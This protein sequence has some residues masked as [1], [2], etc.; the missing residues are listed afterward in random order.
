MKNVL[1]QSAMKLNKKR[2]K[3]QWR[4][5]LVRTLAGVVVFCTTYALILPAITMEAEPSCGMEVHTHE[6]SC[7]T[8]RSEQVFVCKDLQAAH[9]HDDFCYGPEGKLTCPLAE[10]EVHS[11]GEAC[12]QV[13]EELICQPDPELEPEHVHG[14]G[15]YVSQTVLTCE[16][17]PLEAHFHSQGCLAEETR[18]VLICALPEHAHQESCY[19]VKVEADGADGDHLCGMSIHTHAEGCY[20]EDGTLTCSI[21]EHDHE[22][23][24]LVEDLDLNADKEYWLQWVE[25]RDR[26]TFTGNWS[27]DVLTVAKA[28]LGYRE[29]TRN[30]ILVEDALKG[31]TRFGDWYGLP[32]GDWCAMYVSFC[33]DFAQVEGVPLDCAVNPWIDSLKNAE[34]YGEAGIYIPRAG[35]IIFFDYE[36]T[37]EPGIPVI[38]DHVGLVTE[39]LLSEDGQSGTITTIEGN[40]EDQ[41]LSLTYDAKDPRIIG[42]GIL[43]ENPLPQEQW[44]QLRDVTALVE[45]L[46]DA[47]EV[48]TAFDALNL[49]GDK[50]GFEA[51][52]Q[53]LITHIEPILASWESFTEEQKSRAPSLDNVYAL[54]EICGGAAWQELPALAE[55]GAAVTA[56][57]AG[58]PEIFRGELPEELSFVAS[59]Q[60][61]DSIYN[62]DSIRYPFTVTME[63]YY[64]DIHY[65]EARV[66]VELVLP[67]SQSSAEFDIGAVPWLEE[68]VLTIEDRN[69]NGVDIPC[70]VLTGYKH[71]ASDEH[72]GRVVS[73]SFTETVTVTVKDT[74]HGQRVAVLI[75][76]AME[77]NAWEGICTTHGTEEKLS[78]VT[79]SFA[80]YAPLAPEEQQAVYEAYLTELA[81]EDAGSR[82]A[83][84]QA[85]VYDSYCAGHLSDDQYGNLYQKVLELSG[86]D[87]D[88]LA[89]PSQGNGWI[90]MDFGDPNFVAGTQTLAESA[91]AQEFTAQAAMPM[92]FY[93]SLR[94]DSNSQIPDNGWGGENSD[95]NVIWVSK[96]IEGTEQENVFDITLQIITRDTINEV[97]KDPDMAVVV[98]MDISNTMTSVFSG[99]TTVTR[100][101]AAM[102]AAENFLENFAGQTDGISRVGYV[103]FNTHAHEV[104]PMQECSTPAQAKALGQTMRKKTGAIM[105]NAAKNSSDGTYADSY[106]RFTNMEAGLK[107]AA[108]MLSGV[109]NQHKYIIFLSD[110]F[111][112]T[113][114]SSGYKGYNPY[115][116]S[117]KNGTN[118]V[119]YD[120]VMGVHCDYGTSYS[121]TAAIKARELAVSLKSSGISIF[122]IGVDVE[123]QTIQYYH[124]SSVN[125]YKTF[126]VVERRKNAAY[127][128]KNGYEIGT[129]HSEITKKNLT[130]AEKAAMAQDFKDWLK[131]SA[132]AGI[133][134]GYYFDSTDLSGLES[135][136]S[137]IFSKILEMNAES[138]RLDWVATDPMPDMGVHELETME[139]IGFWDIDGVLQNSL[140]GESKDGWLYLNTASFDTT[141]ATISWD[142][143]NS[144]YISTSF[145]DNKNY[146]CALKYR[147]RLQNENQGFVERQIYDT[148]DTTYLHY[149][150]VEVNNGVTSISPRK[151][152]EFPIPK[153]FGYLSELNFHKVDHTGDALSG[154]KFTLTHDTEN[155]GTCR[156]DGVGHVTLPVYEAVSGTDGIVSFT[157]IPSGHHYILT[158]TEAPPGYTLT[159]NRYQV[160]ISYDALTVTVTDADGNPLEWTGSITNHGYYELPNTGGPGTSFFTFGGLLLCGAAIVYGLYTGRKRPKKGDR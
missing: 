100:Y 91:Q 69:I 110:G 126:S 156:G 6:E 70:Q 111:P 90:W 21:P 40:V 19:P 65:S 32:Y 103:A 48:Q 125:N 36:Q 25:A 149:R 73:G 112:T 13:A 123:G 121:D 72:T 117:G 24:C 74:S 145:G 160:V 98:V 5:R 154:A 2:K 78:I 76:A 85:Q 22:A 38:A 96:T 52:R 116:S 59:S 159:A 28:Q 119:F 89:E 97:Y 17:P 114:L 131:G 37:G 4:Q 3:R 146:M 43:P 42:Y 33:L 79:K 12:Y 55:D 152:I 29:S 31:Y 39:V 68:A 10:L 107:M 71:L 50:L 60:R 136:Y 62:G 77:H 153:V 44:Q 147:V 35:D 67:L 30:V 88:A 140:T 87:M 143:K 158:E 80:L 120:A 54:Q 86:V 18:R 83:E 142:L 105:T 45:Q 20:G 53:E 1:L 81:A 16:I 46:P 138:A 151:Y 41:V 124:Q 92:G 99:E 7:W 115:T 113:Y 109:Q 63:S 102:T 82:L 47:A 128:E 27:E 148:N 133:G 122:S 137:Q 9:L 108:N 11:H 57:T 95:G 141:T 127:Y 101:N 157:R 155:C 84:I 8:S 118:G 61:T 14:E 56:L 134:S 106:D 51:L 58:E 34:M 66:K 15:C 64:S 144:G 130:A 132:S 94:L 139:F 135:A 150:V 49:Q 23:A 26:L 104:F 75:G 93:R 129:K